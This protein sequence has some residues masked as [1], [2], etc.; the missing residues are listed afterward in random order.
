MAVTSKTVEEINQAVQRL[1]LKPVRVTE[2]PVELGQFA[3]VMARV[4]HRLAFDQDPSD[5]LRA[6]KQAGAASKTGGR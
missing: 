5:L 3:D 4:R 6:L 2:L 1:A